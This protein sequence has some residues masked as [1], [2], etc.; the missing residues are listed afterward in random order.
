MLNYK[1]VVHSPVRRSD[2]Q[3]QSCARAGQRKVSGY[4]AFIV[5]VLML[6][7]YTQFAAH[8]TVAYTPGVNIRVNKVIL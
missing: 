7:A 8:S 1:Q 2:I 6:T 3:T 5:L 4:F